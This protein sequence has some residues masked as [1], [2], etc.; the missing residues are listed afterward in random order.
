MTQ[1]LLVFIYRYGFCI[2]HNI[3]SRNEA[4]RYNRGFGTKLS[5]GMNLFFRGFLVG[6]ALTAATVAYDKTIGGGN[7]HGH[8][9]EHH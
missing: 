9:K 1:I 8:G 2:N 6:L 7:G 4:W 3:I 5:R